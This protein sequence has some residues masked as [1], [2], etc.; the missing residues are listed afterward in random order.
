[1]V[2]LL[3][4]ALAG[5]ADEPCYSHVFDNR[6][7]SEHYWLEWDDSVDIDAHADDMLQAAEGARAG[8][9]AR[10]WPLTERP[11]IIAIHE[12]GAILFGNAVTVVCT[13][14]GRVPR[15]QLGAQVIDHGTGRMRGVIAHEVVHTAQYGYMYSHIAAI[16]S[17][18]WWLES[19]ASWEYLASEPDTGEWVSVVSGVLDAPHQRHRYGYAIVAAHLSTLDPDLVRQTWEYAGDVAGETIDLPEVLPELGVAWSPFWESFLAH[20]VTADVPYGDELPYAVQLPATCEFPA[21]GVAEE[22]ERLGFSGARTGNLSGEEATFEVF[23]DTATDADWTAV[24][25]VTDGDAPGSPV[26][27]HVVL[28]V[29]DGTGSA[30][31][32]V[33]PG[34]ALWVVASPWSQERG[35]RHAFEWQIDLLEGDPECALPV[36]PEPEDEPGDNPGDPNGPAPLDTDPEPRGSAARCGCESGAPAVGWLVVLLA[37]ATRARSRSCD[38]CPPASAPEAS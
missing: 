37:L 4:A 15:I 26:L 2:L 3:W 21:E 24:A 25:V 1:M 9:I 35:S 32:T 13:D 22:V 31:V 5:A 12:H 30:V 29:N 19:T 16:D 14:I 18:W 36:L 8:L 33:V 7:D 10:G 6:L 38:P 27:E 17:W 11:V 28:D 34:A 20:V 23:I